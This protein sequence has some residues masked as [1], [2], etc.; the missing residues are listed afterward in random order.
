[1]MY[2]RLACLWFLMLPVLALFGQNSKAE[3]LKE[4]DR[5]IDRAEEYDSF[6][7]QNVAQI[8]NAYNAV[9]LPTLTAQY[10]YYLSLYEAYKIFKFDSAFAYAKKLE[11]IASDAGDANKLVRARLRLGFVLLSAG[12]FGEA[13]DVF[14]LIPVS[15]QPDSVKAE[16]FLLKG[17]Y[18]YDLADYTND[19]YFFPAYISKGGVYL[20]SAVALLR[21]TSF[22]YIYYSGLKQMKDGDIDRA[23]VNFKTLM[24]RSDLTDHEVALA[25]STLSFVYIIKNQTEKAID[26]LA[27]ASIADI[28]SSTKETIAMLNLAQTLFQQGDFQRASHY[29]KKAVEDASWYGARQ[30]KVQVNSLMP[31]IQ[32]SE[33]DAI[34]KQ[35]ERLIIYGAVVS[36]IVILFAFLLITIYRQNKKLQRAQQE[37]FKAH[38]QLHDVNAQLRHLNTDLNTAN[39]HL[40][41]LN[42]RLEEANKI[43]EEYVGY[44]FTV[45]A[46]FFQRIEKFKQSIEEKLHYGKTN[47]IKYIVN[48]INIKDEKA[49]LVRRFD[50]AFLKLFP[51]FVAEFN[52]LFDED[53][54]VKLEEGELLNTDLRIYALLRLG[55]KENEKIAEILEYSVKSIYAYKTRIRN[56]SNLPKDEF[57][58]RVMLIKS[59]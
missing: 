51:R 25:A 19:N 43:K 2:K 14:K 17:R 44:F 30:R 41:E 1:M 11:Q 54:K 13:D 53:N 4:L 34:K 45:D 52:L 32:S 49:E 42:V 23:F 33:I 56:K 39:M 27:R 22:E 24:G 48:S 10:D 20:D 9:Q 29:I 26:Y 46:E 58:K 18:Y 15:G 57:D 21:T 35:R 8:R 16:F 28:K 6:K 47:E 5:Y 12:M 7:L 37:I 36:L 40:Q 3:P 50:K 59:V 55:I 31:I 38:T